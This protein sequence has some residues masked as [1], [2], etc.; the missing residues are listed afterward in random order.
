MEALQKCGS[1]GDSAADLLLSE[2][3]QSREQPRALIS[4]NTRCGWAAPAEDASVALVVSQPV[5]LVPS[6][7]KTLKSSTWTLQGMAG[8]RLNLKRVD[9]RGQ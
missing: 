1:P 8:H 4:N 9:E 2:Q 6:G 7:F 3:R 5:Y